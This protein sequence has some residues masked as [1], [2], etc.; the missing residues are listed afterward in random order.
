[1]K[2]FQSLQFKLI[3]G[4]FAVLVPLVAYHLY[5]N[6][7]AIHVVREKV[8]SSNNDLVDLFMQS[9]VDQVLEDTSKYLLTRAAS[10]P[11][12]LSLNLFSDSDGEYQMRKAR[13]INRLRDDLV[14]YSTIN[15]FFVYSRGGQDLTVTDG[16]YKDFGELANW[17]D[18]SSVNDNAGW[19]VLHN[20]RGYGLFTAVHASPDVML[21]AWIDVK[22]LLVPFR[23]LNLGGGGEAMVL[24]ANGEPLTSS[25]LTDAGLDDLRPR[26]DLLDDSYAV[27]DQ[28][29]GKKLAVGTKSAL[30]DIRIVVLVPERSLL[31]RLTFFIRA[32]WIIPIFAILVLGLYVLLLRRVLFMPLSDLM[33][34]MRRII[35]GDLNFRLAED[36]TSELSFLSS[37]Y[38]H[39]ADQIKQLRIG[40]Y[41]QE[42]RVKQAELKHLQVQ[43]N[44]HFYLNS[45]HIIYS[46][47]TL[48]LYGNVQKM[49]L[50]LADYFKFTIRT[51]RSHVTLNE[52]MKHIRNYLEIQKL[53]YPDML[54]F[55]IDIPAPWGEASIPA[56]SIQPFVENAIVHGMR[57]EG[58][59][60]FVRM[61]AE[62]LPNDPERFVVVIA[63]N[64]E[65][66]PA[67]QLSKLAS[68]SYMEEADGSHIGIWNV[69]H[70]LQLYFGDKASAHFANGDP[71]G[72][73]V[74]LTLPYNLGT[75]GGGNEHV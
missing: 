14:L 42:L 15:T 17:L 9:K 73:I 23:Q 56:L 51:N 63:D 30:S 2:V 50:Y 37:T 69:I 36:K 75:D 12:V 48:K 52:E 3:I 62:A 33:R 29:E 10:D 47:A 31:Q 71:H 1:M 61:V 49:A 22:S 45:L 68:G 43:I 44:P 11:D 25:S 66:F 46:L 72:A 53:R 64:G 54:D 70:R 59:S 39:M 20:G 27:L 32:A 26:L 74:R 35:Q 28:P 65:G 57:M 18:K 34:G 67:E 5:T 40:I 60:F 55:E 6:F 4:I 19:T 13:I 58:E 8:A 16:N 38:N 7:Y 24:G 21:G 41:E